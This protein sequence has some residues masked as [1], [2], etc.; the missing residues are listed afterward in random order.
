[1]AAILGLQEVIWVTQNMP[2]AF[3]LIEDGEAQGHGSWR[4]LGSRKASLAPWAM[5]A[6][7]ELISPACGIS[8]ARACPMPLAQESGHP[9][10]TRVPRPRCISIGASGRAGPA[11][12]QDAFQNIPLE[13]PEPFP[14]SSPFPKMTNFG[15]THPDLSGPLMTSSVA[16]SLLRS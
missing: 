9:G 6:R 3:S 1:M 2:V 11:G 15:I 16:G 4:A 5:V 8:R 7:A 14:I 10:D 13:I 12:N